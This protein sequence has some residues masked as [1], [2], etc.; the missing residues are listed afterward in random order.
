MRSTTLTLLLV[1][2]ALVGNAQKKK[3]ITFKSADKGMVSL[4]QMADKSYA[5]T[6]QNP[7]DVSVYR[8]S[9]TVKT[10][11]YLFITEGSVEQK[12]YPHTVLQYK[13]NGEFTRK[14]DAHREGIVDI[15]VDEPNQHLF[16]LRKNEF[17]CFDYNGGLLYSFKTEYLPQCFCCFNKK[18]WYIFVGHNK[19]Q[20][21]YSL[22]STDLKGKEFKEIKTLK[23]KALSGTSVSKIG[24]FSCA[25]NILYVSMGLRNSDKLFAIRDGKMNVINEFKI[26]D[27]PKDRLN[28]FIAPPSIRI[29]NY[30]FWGYNKQMLPSTLVSNITTNKY[31]NIK[32]RNQAGKLISGLKDDIFNTGFIQPNFTSD[33]KS[34]YFYPKTTDNVQSLQIYIVDVK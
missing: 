15:A 18:L 19:D 32:Y 20:V 7:D 30:L 12:G 24:K 8:I 3:I 26:S 14:I 21:S 5:I 28:Q 25:D 16:V 29:G 13:S 1:I 22:C 2:I 9:K 23:E 34:L 10:N 31:E 11:D 33:F 17:K 4:S 27:F 6:L